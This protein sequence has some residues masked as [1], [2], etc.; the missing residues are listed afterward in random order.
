MLVEDMVK[1]LPAIEGYSARQEW[2]AGQL[3]R[4]Y[5]QENAERFEEI[6]ESVMDECDRRVTDA[7]GYGIECPTFEIPLCEAELVTLNSTDAGTII[8][9]FKNLRT[10]ERKETWQTKKY[11]DAKR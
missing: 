2:Y 6:M 8:K 5:V 10:E 3:R 4:A 1:M 9:F 11:H 7:T